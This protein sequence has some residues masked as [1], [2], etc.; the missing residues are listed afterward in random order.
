MNYF[1]QQYDPMSAMAGGMAL[2]GGATNAYDQQLERVRRQREREALAQMGQGDLLLGFEDNPMA[3]RPDSVKALYAS[4]NPELAFKAES[5]AA[6]PHMLNREMN[7]AKALMGLDEERALRMLPHEIEKA[8]QLKE[9]EMAV[10]MG[11]WKEMMPGMFGPGG[12]PAR[13]EG[14]SASVRGGMV[15]TQS[16]PAS[17]FG[18]LDQALTGQG[19]DG[20]TGG[21]YETEFDLNRGP[22][23]KY[24][25]T[26]PLEDEK[27]R[28]ELR[29]KGEETYLK[30]QQTREDLRKN[31][32]AELNKAH[33]HVYM[34]SQA[35]KEL[36]Q[37]I[38]SGDI[39]P[40]AANA[41]LA[42]LNAEIAMAKSLRDELMGTPTKPLQPAPAQPRASTARS[43][44]QPS[45]PDQAPTQV[46]S[47]L[48]YKM[49]Q[50]LLSKQATKKLDVAQGAIES[51]HAE[52]S[53]FSM[54]M[55]TMQNLMNLLATKDVGNRLGQVPG[56]E[57][58]LRLMSADNDNLQKW[59]NELI[60]V[61]KKEG[62]SQLM[63]TLPEL[64]IVSDMFPSVTNS[65]DTNRKAMANVMNLADATM[66]APQF[67][68]NWAANH[69]GTLDGARGMFREWM[70]KNKRYSVESRNG[71]SSLYENEAIPLEAWTKLRQRFTA[72]D[73]M[74]RKDAGKIQI[75]NGKVY[76][77]E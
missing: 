1:R 16:Q 69:G 57:T 3:V 70:Q 29:L 75:I 72:S 34:L 71:Q 21:S 32:A 64:A 50:E 30:Q 73:I 19:L 55:P 35:K 33:E 47:G 10:K 40:G 54:H 52:A 77:Q 59:R 67:L 17:E 46:G 62:Q 44:P 9:M 11:A 28:R 53:K 5:L 76:F 65:P 8:R 2:W 74:K 18:Q 20:L 48:P 31:K 68:E 60:D 4:G 63:N 61:L 23:M 56:G 43:T 24:K 22:V 66:A 27:T 51:A 37:K 58:A 39:A 49:Q 13:A 7:R 14:P 25:A 26:S 42:D 36:Q 6:Q 41:E 45:K 38:A 15:P 12:N